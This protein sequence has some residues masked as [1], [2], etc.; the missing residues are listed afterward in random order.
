MEPTRHYNVLIAGGG[1]TGAALLY[2][3]SK[4]TN[5]GSI[6]LLEKYDGIA[7]VNSK[8]TNNSQTLHFGDIETNYSYDKAI[9][10][11]DAAAMMAR[12]LDH[13][14]DRTS[15]S[16]KYHK[17]VLG[18][19]EKEVTLLT[20]RFE[21]LK[22]AFP[23]LQLIDAKKI[24]E[25]EPSV[26]QGR[27][28]NEP[29]AALFSADGYTVDFQK[30][31]E[32]FVADARMTAPDTTTVLLGTKVI[33]ITKEGEGFRVET[34]R[35]TFTAD[36]VVAALGSYS[37]SFAH[38]LGYGRDYI[39]LPVIGNFYRSTRQLL[40][41]KVYTI[42][43]EKLPFVAVHGDPDVNNPAETRFGPTAKALPILE[44]RNWKTFF[45]FM[46]LFYLDWDSL[47]S[48]FTILA[49]RDIVGFIGHN[50][51]FDIPFFGKHFYAA[52]A[53]KIIP[54]L[55]SSDIV[56]GKGLGGLRPQLVDKKSRKLLMGT[57]EIIGDKI[58]FNV[59][60]SPGATASLKAAE[61]TT[62]KI[63]S[64]FDARFAFDRER[65]LRDH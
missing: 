33:T 15:I 34:N 20:A 36:V 18:V 57:S 59:T 4:Y 14:P 47:A 26:M 28:P 49:D 61:L 65:F 46:R 58:I 30:L 11:R 40:N 19:G 37:L 13:L 54:T 52:T 5:V 53:R 31:A 29:V 64:F 25:L 10:T 8:S 43:K 24:T 41:G 56:F 32:R 48:V 62:E 16:T 21:M 2:T 22:I 45:D 44:R 50:F 6:A 35:G 12:Y 17:M 42:Q 55:R 27:D 9:Q 7:Q 38:A 1:I 63:M 23:S 60:P 39:I 3:I 51:L